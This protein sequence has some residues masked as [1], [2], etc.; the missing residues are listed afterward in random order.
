ML[1]L[2][3]DHGAAF[4]LCVCG[5]DDVVSETYPHSDRSAYDPCFATRSTSLS[6]IPLWM[7]RP[8]SIISAPITRLPALLCLRGLPRDDGRHLRGGP[9][10]RMTPIPDIGSLGKGKRLRPIGD[11]I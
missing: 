3:L 8:A 5:I 11:S 9:V 7:A 2:G 10:A 1:Q 6:T 4:E